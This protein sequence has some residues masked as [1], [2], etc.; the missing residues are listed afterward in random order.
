MLQDMTGQTAQKQKSTTS[1]F[2]SAGSVPK[3]ARVAMM[4]ELGKIE[5]KEYPIPEI[6]DGDI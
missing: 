4:T 3:T 1:S 2:S 6:G 5:L